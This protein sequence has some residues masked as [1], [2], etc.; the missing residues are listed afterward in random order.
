MLNNKFLYVTIL[1]INATL[2]GALMASSVKYLSADLHPITI[3]FYRSIVGLILVL[4][5]IIKNNF[6][7]LKSKNIKLQFS[8]SMIN[9]DSMICWFILMEFSD[10]VFHIH[11]TNDV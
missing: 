1:S 5:F 6:K 3:A 9:S 10:Y 7:A 8:R 4:P 11:G 2:F